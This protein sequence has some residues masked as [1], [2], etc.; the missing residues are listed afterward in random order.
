M[1]TYEIKVL[2]DVEALEIHIEGLSN[3]PLI[4]GDKGDKGDKGEKGD[5]GP[6]GL[7][8]IKGD[9]GEKG[10]TGPQ[11][12]QGLQ[13]IKG[14]IGERGPQGLQGI[15][16]DKGDKGEAF[17]YTDFTEEQLKILKGDKGEQG[18]QGPQGEQGIQGE[19]GPQG[20]KGPKGEKGDTGEN[21]SI[22]KTYNSISNMNA[23][24]DN[25]KEGKFVIIASETEDPDN[26]KLYVKGS[27]AFIYLTDLSGSQGIQGKQ[28]PQGEIG[29]KGEQGERGIQGIQG[30]EGKQG[31]QGV[32]GDKGDVG[33]ANYLTIGTVEKG[34]VPKVTIIG[35]A[36]RQTI[37]FVLPKG[38]KGDKGDRGPVGPQGI[39]GLQGVQGVKGDTGPQ[40]PIGKTGLQGIQ[41]P[42]GDTGPKGEP[43]K[44]EN[45]TP[46][47]LQ[48]LK[49][50][51]GD[52]GEQGIQGP[53]GLQG[54]KGEQGV[55][56][57]K[58]ERGEIGPQGVGIK[59]ITNYY[60]ATNSTNV[61]INTAGW[62]NTIQ[63]ISS[64]K[65]YL[66]NYKKN[67]YTNNS[68]DTTTPCIIGAY[69]DKGDTGLAA[70][71]GNVTAT[72][73]NNVGVPNI[74]VTTEGSNTAKTFKF[75]FK[76]LKGDKGDI[77]PQGPIGKTGPQGE[78]GKNPTIFVTKILTT[79]EIRQ[80]TNYTIPQYTLGNNSLNLY[81][82]CCKLIKDVHYKE[83]SN[84][85]IQFIDWNV[86]TG[87]NLEILIKK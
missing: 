48:A 42:K 32:K 72:V 80:N 25:V 24:K 86:P 75:A 15:K 17:K 83:I 23:D 49:G 46:E 65:K 52:K 1:S 26:S 73:D 63:T 8:G 41:G 78:P 13:G 77:G 68:M 21:F 30:P 35:E 60:L 84:T 79:Q 5:T 74:E 12:I 81:F 38:D 22:F 85:S 7:Q 14:E 36:P 31:I 44:Y 29:P 61:T 53:M 39:Q 47:Q 43:F 76:N 55:Q 11:G 45:F 20:I 6:Q 71:F 57:P 28:G 16:G 2:T 56:G 70:G 19:R 9:K 3:I 82:E 87:S 54:S 51:K 67:I 69:G 50:P 18:I 66:W 58:G 10:D 59:S 27:T 62:S 37:N 33:P 64:S 34:E 40:G 4:K